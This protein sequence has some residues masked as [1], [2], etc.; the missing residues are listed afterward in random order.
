MQCSSLLQCTSG[1]T[2]RSGIAPAETLTNVAS[3]KSLAF[4]ASCCSDG[5][6]GRGP[7][8]L[9][10]VGSK[11]SD[12]ILSSDSV[13]WAMMA[14]SSPLLISCIVMMS[15]NVGRKIGTSSSSLNCGL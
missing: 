11:S 14:S 6:A 3:I 9:S 15:A 5:G 4:W 1:E 2:R 8:M 12:L 7:Y 10:H 13:V